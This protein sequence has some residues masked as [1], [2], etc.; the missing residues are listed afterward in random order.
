MVALA[1]QRQLPFRAFKA[2][3]PAPQSAPGRRHQKMQPAAIKELVSFRCGLGTANLSISQSHKGAS[4]GWGH[5][6]PPTSKIM[7]PEMPPREHGFPNAPPDV[8]T[9]KPLSFQRLIG[10]YWKSSDVSKSNLGRHDWIRTN[11]LFR[12]KEAL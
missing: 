5:I 11:D 2:V 6:M 3:L 12:V 1:A 9:Q 8:K 7:P 10:S 4:N